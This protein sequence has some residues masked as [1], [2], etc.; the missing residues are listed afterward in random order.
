MDIQRHVYFIFFSSRI[1]L[2]CPRSLSFSLYGKN[3]LLGSGGELRCLSCSPLPLLSNTQNGF[4]ASDRGSEDL[5]SVTAS[6]SDIQGTKHSRESTGNC[7]TSL[8]RWLSGW[9]LGTRVE[10]SSSSSPLAVAVTCDHNLPQ[11]RLASWL[12]ICST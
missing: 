2:P 11:P 9:C 10:S 5:P 1:S 8:R 6:A 12:L 7:S 3:Q 4:V